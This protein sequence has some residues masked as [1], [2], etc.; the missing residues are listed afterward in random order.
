MS[1]QSLRIRLL[2]VIGITA[3][4]FAAILLS[5]AARSSSAGAPPPLTTFSSPIPPT[6]L[7][8]TKAGPSAV[9]PNGQVAYTLISAN[10]SDFTVNDVTVVDVLPAGLSFV[11]ASPSPNLQTL[12]VLSW[13][14]G[15]LGPGEK[16]TIIITT[17]A[18][19]SE[20]PYASLPGMLLGIMPTPWRQVNAWLPVELPLMPAWYA[21][22]NNVQAGADTCRRAIHIRLDVLE[23][24]PEEPESGVPIFEL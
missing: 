11:A 2:V 22:G 9:L 10:K 6:W 23:E 5:T 12:P 14:L 15:D 17:T 21:T 20:I 24:R 19:S 8:L 3:L 13:S 1:T 18:P 16:R 4:W 7:D